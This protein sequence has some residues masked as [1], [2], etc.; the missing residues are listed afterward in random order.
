M[1]Y[2]EVKLQRLVS[3]LKP[4]EFRPFK[5]IITKKEYKQYLNNIFK[6]KDRLYLPFISSRVV[7]AP[8]EIKNFLKEKEYE[9]VDYGLG[10]AK[11]NNG[12]L[13]KIGKIL[14]KNN[15][16]RLL[17]LFNVTRQGITKNSLLIIISRHPYD[18]IGA[19][20][21]RG[22]TSCLDLGK[23]VEGREETVMVE[24]SNGT[25]IAYLIDS[26]DVNINTPIARLLIKQYVNVKNKKDII[27]YPEKKSIWN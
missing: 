11:N 9:I 7:V 23:D 2:I 12:R 18:I 3:A 13:L 6:D 21:H 20:T 24:I 1:K 19:S 25:I 15:K 8:P 10:I 26:K 22:W 16:K 4:S 27:S 14:S 5:D 17:D